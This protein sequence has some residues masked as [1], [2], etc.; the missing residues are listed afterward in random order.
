MNFL[1]SNEF[2]RA[3]N[4]LSLILAGAWHGIGPEK[5]LLSGTGDRIV[6]LFFFTRGS[7][8]STEAT[9]PTL[10]LG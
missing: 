8:S 10:G 7:I 1:Y 6:R 5:F 2:L 4:T 3:I 9:V